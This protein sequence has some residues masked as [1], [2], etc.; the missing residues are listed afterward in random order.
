VSC[1]LATKPPGFW[2]ALKSEFPESDVD[3]VVRGFVA[4]ILVPRLAEAG[5]FR[6]VGG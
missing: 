5:A 6:L 3:S 2:E 4:H 1:A